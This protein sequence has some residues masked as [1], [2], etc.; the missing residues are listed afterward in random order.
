MKVRYTPDKYKVEIL[1]EFPE[2][3][4]LVFAA[5]WVE[6][7]TAEKPF[8]INPNYVCDIGID[9]GQVHPAVFTPAQFID[10]KARLPGPEHVFEM[11]RYPVLSE[12]IVDFYRK[13]RGEKVFGDASHKS[14]NE[15]LEDAGL[16][17][18]DV[19]F[20][21]EKQRMIEM[22]QWLLYKNMIE[23]S[24][25]N[26]TLIDQMKKYRWEISP[27]GKERPIK[28]NDDAVDSGMLSVFDLIDSRWYDDLKRADLPQSA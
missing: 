24:P 15:R 10:G 12:K 18:Y 4:A 9:W 23:I 5:D 27:S 19:F 16:N 6:R 22:M 2:G 1:G 11:M 21:K 8:G 20:V 13:N 25:D 17:V 7:C 14:E 3:G 28:K 26:E